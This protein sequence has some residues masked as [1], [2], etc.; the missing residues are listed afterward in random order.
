MHNEEGNKRKNTEDTIQSSKTP[1]KNPMTYLSVLPPDVLYSI[2]KCRKDAA[3][4]TF[5]QPDSNLPYTKR[6]RHVHPKRL[7][8]CISY[9]YGDGYKKLFGTGTPPMD[10]LS[11]TQQSALWDKL[12]LKLSP[13]LCGIHDWKE[14]GLDDLQDWLKDYPSWITDIL[15]LYA[16][17]GDCVCPNPRVL[18]EVQLYDLLK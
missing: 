13:K 8:S 15:V 3:F 4:E 10:T 2:L 18:A 14:W 9:N 16:F 1:K 7:W 5:K 11:D 6:G 12:T 17:D